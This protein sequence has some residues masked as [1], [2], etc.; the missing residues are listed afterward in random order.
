MSAPVLDALLLVG[1]LMIGRPILACEG[2]AEQRADIVRALKLLAR[3]ALEELG[4]HGELDGY[5]DL[6]DA[7]EAGQRSKLRFISGGKRS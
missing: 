4:Q 3:R 7:L 1:E 5:C 6:R 2:T